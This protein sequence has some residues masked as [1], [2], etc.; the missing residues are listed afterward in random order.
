MPTVSSIPEPSSIADWSTVE[1]LQR[2]MIEAVKAMEQMG[3]S[4]GN[5]RQV[6]EYNSDQRKRCLAIVAFPLIK[7]GESATA[8]ETEARS[9]PQYEAALKQ[10]A[11]ELATAETVRAEYENLRLQWETARSLLSLQK[12]SIRNL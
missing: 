2:R 1:D 11:K 5:A 4:I 3:P 7:A 6:I 12:E 9:S 8:A 10:L